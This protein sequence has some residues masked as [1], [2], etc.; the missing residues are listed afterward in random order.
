MRE[1][2]RFLRGMVIDQMVRELDEHRH[3]SAD[4]DLSVSSDL[5]PILDSAPQVYETFKKGLKYLE[6]AIESVRKEDIQKEYFE[7]LIMTAAHIQMGMLALH[8][9]L[10]GSEAGEGS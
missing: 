8:S 9:A 5:I 6:D 10:V 4:R 2:Q 7:D 1:D 3:G